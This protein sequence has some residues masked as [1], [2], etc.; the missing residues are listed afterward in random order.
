[1]KILVTGAGGFLGTWVVKKLIDSGYQDIVNFSRHNYHHLEA[2]GVKNVKGDLSDKTDVENLLKE[3]RFDVIFHIAAKAGIWGRKKD[4]FAINYEGTKNLVDM[5]KVNGVKKFI[6]TS[7]PS[8][9]FYKS[10]HENSDESTPYPKGFLSHY[11]KSK[12]LAEEYVLGQGSESFL[13]CALRPHLL[14]GPGDPHIL[15]RLI[16]RAR[17]GKL[18][19][20]GDGNNTVDTTYVEN[21]ASAHVLALENLSFEF[22][23]RPY[24][25]GDQSPVKLWDFINKILVHAGVE[26]V[27]Q[28]ISLKMAYFLGMISEFVYRFLGIVSPEPPMTRFLALNLSISHYFNLQQSYAFLGEYQK[29]TPEE[30]MRRT[31][32]N[33]PLKRN[34]STENQT[35]L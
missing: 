13:V 24:F 19:I 32:K 16:A 30:G 1:M 2:L 31:F 34:K 7:T 26:P 18:K 22:S 25:V 5:A 27:N 6:Y 9:V 21:A 33:S 11:S 12:R 14:W 29:V 8:V 3:Y 20:I 4:Y 17:E 23:G 15:P 28:Y 35:S 10:P